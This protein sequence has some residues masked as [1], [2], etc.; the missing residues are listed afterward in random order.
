M[1]IC[2]VLLV[3]L[4]GI[5][6]A[7]ALTRIKDITDVKGVRANQ[8]VG[9]G[10]VVGLNNTGDT[11]RN[12]PFTQQSLQAMLD[13]MGVNIRGSQ[14]IPNTRNVAAVMVTA[15]LPPFATKGTRFDVTVAS[16]GDA[17]SLAGG[18][19]IMTSLAGA[20]QVIYA[21][22]QGPITISGYL[23]K[24]AAESIT[25][26]FQMARSSKRMHRPRRWTGCHLSWS[27][28]I[29]ISLRQSASWTP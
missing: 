6:S 16:M 14:Y 5:D 25:A 1:R 12:A 26:V 17:K 13:R 19:L 18:S 11:L 15:E 20:D 8:L 7:S 22:A 10:L 24:G 4:L 29:P 21:A 28:A 2:I 27:F 23:A 9:Y 3:L